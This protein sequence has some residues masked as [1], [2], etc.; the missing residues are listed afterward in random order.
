MVDKVRRQRHD[1]GSVGDVIAAQVEHALRGERRVIETPDDRRKR[2]KADIRA[3]VI[4][5]DRIRELQHAL[6]DARDAWQLAPDHLRL[7]LDEG[8]RLVGHPGLDGIDASDLA[9]QAWLLRRLPPTWADCRAS[10]RDAKG[11]LLKLVF[12]PELA[13]DRDDAA[14]LHLDHPLMKRAL[15]V[16]RKNLWSAGLHASHQIQRA[17]Y[18]V[19]PDRDCDR[20]VVVLVSRLIVISVLGAKLHEELLLTDN[21]GSGPS[22]KN[23]SRRSAFQTPSRWAGAT[24]ASSA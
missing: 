15:A 11:R 17:S 16:F 20:L 24:L 14:I 6:R 3:E 9:G 7:V 13:R 23:G 5:Q 19:V 4:T 10:I 8:L 2:L 18:C 1:L 12:D 21:S 22:Q